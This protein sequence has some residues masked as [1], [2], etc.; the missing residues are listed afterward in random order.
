M[1]KIN[2]EG[3]VS[4]D[5]P[6]Y[7]YQRDRVEV[8]KQKNKISLKNLETIGKQIDR[9]PRLIVEYFKKYFS[10]NF[11]FKNGEVTTT[12]TIEG[13]EF[14]KALCQFI[15]YLVLCPVCK[16]PE[17][18][19]KVKRKGV[20]LSCKCCSFNGTIVEKSIKNKAVLKTVETICKKNK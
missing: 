10:V 7:R 15:E 11:I 18:E 9:D 2:I 12:K 13:N 17:T 1:S 14:E 19:M 3:L 8:V 5:D 6:F 16:L 4:I 20:N